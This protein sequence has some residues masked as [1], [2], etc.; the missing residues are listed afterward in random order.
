MNGP[1]LW[2]SLPNNIREIESL[3]TF[4]KHIKT[5]LFKGSFKEAFKLLLLLLLN[6]FPCKND[7]WTK[8][9]WLNYN[10]LN[11]PQMI[12]IHHHP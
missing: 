8:S 12:K 2:N 1:M 9:S 10:T 7:G 11:N 5:F 6:Y 4:K 3:S